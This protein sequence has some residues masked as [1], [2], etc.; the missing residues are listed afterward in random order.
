M[1]RF[2]YLLALV[3]ISIN[4]FGQQFND[5]SPK[6]HGRNDWTITDMIAR[7]DLYYSFVANN[8]GYALLY[9]MDN[10]NNPIEKVDNTVNDGICIYPKTQRELLLYRQDEKGKWIEASNAVQVDSI[11]PIMD[12]D[13]GTHKSY[14]YCNDFMIN[15]RDGYGQ[16]RLLN[17]GWVVMLLGNNY[18]IAKYDYSDMFRYVSIAIFVPNG[19]GTYTATRFEP[20][21]RKT[22]QPELSPSDTLKITESEN[23]IKLEFWNKLSCNKNEKPDGYVIRTG[24]G[25]TVKIPY[26]K[27]TK[28]FAVMNF[29]L[30]GNGIHYSSDY[31]LM[32]TK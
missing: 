18:S 25:G 9:R 7:S 3:L 21:N 27:A 19:D 15:K 12:K 11:Y 17:N 20:L 32:W 23:G 2:I 13:F 31:K 1:K 30:M 24:D 10:S 5:F 4:S 22:I 26:K 16:V 29:D 8:V 28:P 6:C 14:G